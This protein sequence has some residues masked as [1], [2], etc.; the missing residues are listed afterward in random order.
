MA[1][2]SHAAN[3]TLPKTNVTKSRFGIDELDILERVFKANPK[4]TTQTKRKFANDMGVDLL[5][6]NVLKYGPYMKFPLS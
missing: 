3:P 1:P 5:R 2:Q 4:P 6:I